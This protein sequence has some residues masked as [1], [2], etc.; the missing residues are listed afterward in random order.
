MKMSEILA[1][2]GGKRQAVCGLVLALPCLLLGTAVASPRYHGIAVPPGARHAW[3]VMKDSVA[4][5][6][7]SDFGVTWEFQ[8][9]WTIRDFSDVFFLDSLQG[10]TCG[11]LGAIFRTTDGGSD[12]RQQ[13]LGGPFFCTRIRFLNHT[14]G[15]ATGIQTW[16]MRTATGGNDWKAYMLPHP[17]YHTDSVHLQGLAVV[18]P[19]TAWFVAGNCGEWGPAHD[20]GQ[21]YIVRTTNAGDSWELVAKNHLYDFFDVAFT[22]SRSGFVV[23]GEDRNW[24]AYMA[25]TTD[26]GRGWFSATIPHQAR[27][28]R[29]IC[30]ASSRH[31]WACGLNG[32]VVHTSD[33]GA[34]WQ[35]QDSPVDDTLFDI[36]FCDTLHGM[37]AA[38]AGVLRTTDG[39]WTWTQAFPAI[40]ETPEPGRTPPLHPTVMSRAQLRAGLLA[41]PSLSVFD[42][43]GRRVFAP[44]SGVF[45]L[46]SAAATRR[47]L[48]AH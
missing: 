31:G 7:S 25:R 24:K 9:V 10:W 20:S 15:W 27:F 2:A 28:L 18:A 4:I 12:W 46:R 41:D 40:A 37:I 6:H 13:N 30:F 17:P 5:Y 45:F 47:V 36:E 43:A 26:G 8:P 29:S 39:G 19:D 14:T 21:G 42:A 33:G 44:K 11:A 1:A 22:D 38:C 35:L 34:S 32:T 3:A 48:V 16:L 23:G